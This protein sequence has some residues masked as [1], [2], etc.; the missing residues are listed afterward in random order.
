MKIKAVA[1]L[2]M[3]KAMQAGKAKNDLSKICKLIAFLTG[4]SYRKIYSEFQ[5]GVNLSDYHSQQIDEL[6]KIFKELELS[7]SIIKDRQY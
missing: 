2:E 4:N 5:K 3:L 1:I 7:I 6:N